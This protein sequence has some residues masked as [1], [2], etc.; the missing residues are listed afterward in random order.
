MLPGAAQNGR[1][2]MIVRLRALLET[3]PDLVRRYEAAKDIVRCFRRPAFYEVATRCNLFCEGCYYFSDSL[4]PVTEE[5][6]LEVWERFF[7]AEAARGVTMAYFIGAEPALEQERLIAASPYF[8]RGN[9]GTNGTIRIDP[10]IPFRIG[11]S[12]W[13]DDDATDAQLRGASTFRKAIANYRGDP[14]AIVVYTFS[15]RNL[16]GARRVAETCRD[17]GLE[18]TFNMYSPTST[19]LSRL[20]NWEGNDRRYFRFSRPED[21]LIFDDES[22]AAVRHEAQRLIEDFPD[23]VVYSRAYNDWVT[24]SGPL[25][26]ID[27]ETRVAPD[28]RSRIVSPLTYHRADLRR[29]DEKCC[30]PD[31]DCSQCRM[32]SSGW[33]S[34][35]EPRAEDIKN[36]ASFEDWLDMI[37]TLG[38]IFMRERPAA[39]AAAE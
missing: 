25:H 17:N 3:A 12:V 5:T 20:A 4:V 18:L 39:A 30:T 10:S 13:A 29:S 11:L 22:L 24:Q 31:V 6:S 21:T 32:Y 35:F 26:R 38:R 7:R 27:P 9:I 16:A 33:S 28:C 34:R 15:R 37:E 23:T 36:R 19:Y 2:T 1:R 8:P 14:R